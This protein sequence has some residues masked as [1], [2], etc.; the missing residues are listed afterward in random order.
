MKWTVHKA[1]IE[2][3]VDRKSLAKWL[4]VL[5][6]DLKKGKTYHTRDISRAVVG[7]LD[8]E[9]TRNE[10]AAA[11]LR[12]LEL[13][14]KKAELVPMSEAQQL[15][16]LALLPIRQRLLAMPSEICTRVNPTDPQF[17]RAQAQVWVDETLATI[18]EQLPKGKGVE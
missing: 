9:R 16:T 12:E 11:S 8:F 2:W 1:A 3:G 7:D 18:R 4:S 5:G 10:R 6:F 15:Y 13:A 14:Q 17:A